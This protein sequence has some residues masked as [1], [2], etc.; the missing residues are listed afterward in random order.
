MK[1]VEEHLRAAQALLEAL[2]NGNPYQPIEHGIMSLRV[3]L[4]GIVLK[5]FNNDVLKVSEIY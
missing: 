1:E 4:M 5:E 3:Q 2:P